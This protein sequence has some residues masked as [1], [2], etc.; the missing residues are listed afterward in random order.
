MSHTKGPYSIKTHGSTISI[1]A[2]EKENGW[3]T[4]LAEI[5]MKNTPDAEANARLFA[6]APG[7]KMCCEA[8]LVY[9][10]LAD[11]LDKEQLIEELKRVLAKAEGR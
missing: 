7:L 1:L 8:S 11:H 3:S 10:Q 9:L 6:A 2:P 5:S 4:V